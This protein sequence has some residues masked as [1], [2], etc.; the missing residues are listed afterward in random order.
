MKKLIA[1]LMSMLMV[2]SLAA[3][4]SNDQPVEAPIEPDNVVTEQPVV[5]EPIIN[6]PVEDPYS[7][8][9][10]IVGES[11]SVPNVGDFVFGN[12]EITTEFMQGYQC[13]EYTV[14]IPYTFIASTDD[15]LLSATPP[16]SGEIFGDI[17]YSDFVAN[18]RPYSENTEYITAGNTYNGVIEGSFLEFD[19]EGIDT[20]YLKF[21]VEDRTTDATRTFYID[22]ALPA[23]E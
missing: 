6:E 2:M 7:N 10:V 13:N 3:C 9:N 15:S 5:D 20:L 19:A 12:I 17:E 8:V 11:Y 16:A 22:V 23:A 21:G 14:S 1:L 18:L 4:G